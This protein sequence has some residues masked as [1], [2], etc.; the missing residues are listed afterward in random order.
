MWPT[1]DPSDV[2]DYELDI[3]AALVGSENDSIASVTAVP[4]PNGTGDISINSTATDGSVVIFWIAAGQSGT[5]YVV[6]VTITTSL[7]RTLGRAVLLPVLSLTDP[8]VPTNALTTDQ[9]Q[10]ITDQ[11]G[12]PILL[13][14]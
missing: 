11:N 13:G 4:S 5:T 10:T 14:S 7:G 1:K 12:N 3:A 8:T 2:L 9:G 6:Q